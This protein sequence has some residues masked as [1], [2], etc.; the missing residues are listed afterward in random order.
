MADPVQRKQG[1]QWDRIGLQAQEVV[2]RMQARVEPNPIPVKAL[3]ALGGIGHGLRLPLQ[4]L[5]SVHAAEA[6]RLHA[7]IIQLE[8]RCHIKAA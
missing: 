5:S 4:R 7:D 6:Q 8:Q 1:F 3:L 2:Q